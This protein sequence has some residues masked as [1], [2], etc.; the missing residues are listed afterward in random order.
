MKFFMDDEHQNCI[1]S[2]FLYWLVMQLH[3]ALLP[4]IWMGWEGDGA[5]RQGETSIFPKNN[6]LFKFTLDEPFDSVELAE[7]DGLRW[8]CPVVLHVFV[9][10]DLFFSHC[11]G[12]GRKIFHSGR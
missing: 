7:Q 2:A 11:F 4:L 8:V 10:W 5:C 6:I 9:K 1:S 3:S 12:P